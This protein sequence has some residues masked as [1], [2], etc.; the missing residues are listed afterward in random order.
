MARSQQ[1]PRF[2]SYE[3]GKRR[4]QLEKERLLEKKAQASSQKAAVGGRRRQT[5]DE[6]A[7]KNEERHQLRMAEA[8]AGRRCI[9][10]QAKPLPGK[11]KC[12]HHYVR[13]LLHGAARVN[14][15]ATLESGP[16][17]FQVNDEAVGWALAQ[18][19]EQ[20]GLCYLSGISLVIGENATLDHVMSRGRYLHHHIAGGLENLRWA[21][22]DVNRAKNQ[23]H[24]AQFVEL[25]RRVFQ[26][27]EKKVEARKRA[28]MNPSRR[29]AHRSG[30][31][32]HL[33]RPRKVTIEWAGSY[34]SLRTTLPPKPNSGKQK[35]FG[36][37]IA[38]GLHK[39]TPGVEVQLEG[40]ADKLMGQLRDGTFSWAEWG[41]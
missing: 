17:A 22:A 37:R 28:S 21:D 25:C 2:H 14:T 10:C 36:Q 40:M 15:G 39:D 7:L 3:E 31:K 1:K 23:L 11:T 38:T 18:F 33:G 34:A 16:A 41:Y 19:E 35:A 13:Q 4:V 20:R 32:P 29:A 24:P 12:L 5:A 6:R 30:Y 9:S 27:H 26:W 8:K